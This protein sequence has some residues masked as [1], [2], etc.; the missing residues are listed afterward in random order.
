MRK[1]STWLRIPLAIIEL[2]RNTDTNLRP[3]EVL[4]FGFT[5]IR[6]GPDGLISRQI[7]REMTTGFISAEGAQVLAPNWSL[8]HPLVQDLFGSN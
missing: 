2:A 8:I 6:V 4:R 7:T 5:L 3:L 1:P